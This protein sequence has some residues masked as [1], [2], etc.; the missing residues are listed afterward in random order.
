MCEPPRT[1]LAWVKITEL[2][3]TGALNTEKMKRGCPLARSDMW[4]AGATQFSTASR[5]VVEKKNKK[6][7]Q[8]P[9]G[10]ENPSF[11]NL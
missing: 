7:K 4:A 9:E 3:G 2:A 11:V 10:N 8:K 5:E 6:Q 1:V